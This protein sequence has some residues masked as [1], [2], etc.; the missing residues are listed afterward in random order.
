[1]VELRLASGCPGL[2]SSGGARRSASISAARRGGERL[3]LRGQL[4]DLRGQRP[5]LRFQAVD[6]QIFGAAVA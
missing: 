2:V 3:H 1:V 5:H 4:L 6:A